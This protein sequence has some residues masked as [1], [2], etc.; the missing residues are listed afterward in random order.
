MVVT[1][2]PNYAREICELDSMACGMREVLVA[3]GV[4]CAPAISTVHKKFPEFCSYTDLIQSSLLRGSLSYSCSR[5]YID[6]QTAVL[7]C[8]EGHD[9]VRLTYILLLAL[10]GTALT[11]HAILTSKVIDLPAHCGVAGAL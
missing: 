10:P 2:S 8:Y 5:V 9:L 7:H 6:L 1:V 4:R 3:A 11:E